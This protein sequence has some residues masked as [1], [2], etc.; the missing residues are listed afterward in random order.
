M[1][2]EKIDEAHSLQVRIIPDI[3]HKYDVFDRELSEQFALHPTRTLRNALT[4]YYPRRLV[5]GLLQM[6]SLDGEKHSARVSRDERKQVVG[7]L[8]NG[9]SLTL[10][11][12]RPG[13]EFVTAGG[14]E[15]SEIN[16]ET[17]ESRIH[18]RLYFAG[19]LLDV[20][21]VTGGFNLQA[22]WA[23]GRMAGEGMVGQLRVRS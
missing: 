14:V 4:E 22:C 10:V 1:A 16:P 23:T 9:I 20:D 5:D 19:E 8:C 15:L 2:F 18:P 6:F 12:R 11:S 13:D 17:M 21:A 7:A 3:S